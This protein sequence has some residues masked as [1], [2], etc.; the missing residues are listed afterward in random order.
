MKLH[1][2]KSFS[3]PFDELVVFSTNMPPGQLMD[4]AFLRR[5]PYKIEVAGPSP[6][7]F[8]DIFHAVARA[9]RGGAGRGHRLRRLRAHRAPRRRARRVPARLHRRPGA[10]GLQIP[11]RRPRD[12]LA[13]AIGN[14]H[15]KEAPGGYGMAPRKG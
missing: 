1:T 14:L 9:G 3:L 12:M 5:I 10:R 13:F 6:A 15:P 4:P 11:R 8:G 2:G 7:E